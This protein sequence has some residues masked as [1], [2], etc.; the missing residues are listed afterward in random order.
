MR[1]AAPARAKGSESGSV[2][3]D[4]IESL[5][6]PSSRARVCV[7]CMAPR[8]ALRTGHLR[9]PGRPYM[10]LIDLL[11]NGKVEE[12]NQTRGHRA[13]LDLY[14]ADLSNLP[15]GGVDLSSA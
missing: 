14:A 2:R 12:F 13:P 7:P 10:A 6:Q 15:L 1:V 4:T 3:K 11:L 5:L 9:K 8:P